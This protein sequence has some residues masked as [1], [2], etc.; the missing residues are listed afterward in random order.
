M[1]QTSKHILVI[2]LSAMG[3][4]AMTVP[5]IK[6]MVREYPEV[7]I[8]VVSRGFFQ[9]IFANIPNVSFYTADVK[10]K[11]KGVFG[12]FKLYKELKK[13][14]IDVVADLHNVLRSKILRFFFFLGGYKI[15]LIDKGRAEKK[16]LTQ[17]KIFQQLKTTH[18][19][20]ADV[21]RNLGYNVSL[22]QDDVLQPLQ[23]T[24]N[25]QTILN[26]TTKKTI[27]IAPFAAFAGKTYPVA[28]MEAV[29][30]KL[31]DT[32]NYHIILFGGPADV[33]QLSTWE[34]AYDSVTNVAGK[35]SFQEELELISNLDVMLSMDS[36]NAHLAAMFG[37]KV[38]TIWGVTHPF[39]GFY[40]F[41]QP[42]ENALLADK[43]K[44]PLVPTSI[45]GNKYPEGY[46]NV[47]QTITPE[48]VVKKIEEV[49]R[50]G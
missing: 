13:L 40:P 46:E 42:K 14:H 38:I 8:T 15:A 16:A 4:V 1:E 7:K 5:V 23:L 50:N 30:S 24:E 9:P 29:I 43:E 18:E 28:Q 45:Y 44:Y 19:R 21:F 2:R 35:L 20:Y 11:H 36:G 48:A 25:S 31:A 26:K 32:K 49:L 47:M 6:A 37:R 3:D 12:L 33:A 39:A 27:G 22:T 34:E 17:G 10:G 41:G